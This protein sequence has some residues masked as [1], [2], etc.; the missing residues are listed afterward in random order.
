MMAILTSVMWYVNMFLHTNIE[1]SE[2][3]KNSI[4]NCIQKNMKYQ[5]INLIKEVKDLNNLNSKTL[6]KEIKGGMD[7]CKHISLWVLDLELS[8]H[9]VLIS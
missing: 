1:V 6:M 5:V 4:Y 9:S 7:K 8:L 2:R 3:E